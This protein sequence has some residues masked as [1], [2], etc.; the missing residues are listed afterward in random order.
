M[1]TI[2]LLWE[3]SHLRGNLRKSRQEI[4]ALQEKKLRTLLACAYDRSAWHRGRFQAAGFRR[5]QLSS[6]PLAA[7]PTMDKADLLN[8]FDQIVTVP[9]VYQEDLRRFDADESRRG[10]LFQGKYHIVH[11]SGSTGKPGY[12]LYD[13][14]AWDQMLLGIIRGALWGMTGAEIAKLLL[15]GPRIVYL[16]ATGRRYGGAMAVGDGVKGL[17]ATQLHLDVNTPLP[18][19]VE[20]VRSFRPNIIIGYPSAVKILGEL[21]QTRELELDV[22]RVI[23][24]G[25]P[26]GS[27]LRDYFEQV[28]HGD[29]IN[30]YGASESLALG[31]ESGLSDGMYLFDDLNVIEVADGELYLTCLYNL[32]QP[33]I[34][35]HLSDRLSLRP[36]DGKYPFT[37]SESVQGRSEDLL[38]FEDGG[39]RDFLHPLSIEGFCI[40]GLLDIQF[41]QTGPASFDAR[42]ET[43]PEVRWEAVE[44][45]LRRQIKAVLHEK[46]LV[47]VDFTLRRIAKIPPDPRTGKKRL[48][49]PLATS[50][51]DVHEEAAV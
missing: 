21:V 34:R 30:F 41:C 16:A 33:L 31:V 20:R 48:V 29:V 39:R 23:S 3:L 6:I 28:F 35:Y 15:G 10:Q 26:L 42:L 49:I 37:R 38:W 24:C 43:A 22:L 17:R 7:L 51:G 9:G 25:E 4:S 40:E 11:S 45:E 13:A 1:N 50:S 19:L 32:A 5:E 44:S 27:G 18:E 2:K 8:N 36:A 46:G 12:F 47:H 14:A